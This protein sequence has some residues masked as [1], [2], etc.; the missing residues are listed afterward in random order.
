MNAP[1]KDKV[2]LLRARDGDKCWF[3]DGPLR[4][5]AGANSKKAPSIEH[6]TPK[7]LGGNSKLENL[8]LCHPGCNRHLADRPRERKELMR[9]KR[10]G[11]PLPPRPVPAT[12][13]SIEGKKET[14]GLNKAQIDWRSRFWAMTVIAALFAG[15]TVGQ[16]IS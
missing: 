5:N 1:L 15:L 12:V 9:A 16:W 3:C 14:S 6:L 7:A 11:L 4:F 8:V 2:A 10:L 13:R